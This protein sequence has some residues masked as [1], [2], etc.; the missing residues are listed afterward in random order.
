MRCVH[1]QNHQIS[2]SPGDW[3]ELGAEGLAEQML[4]LQAQGAHNISLVTPS[5]VVPQVVA[6]LEI[7]AAAG[8]ELPLVYNTS[9][10]D[11]V[12]VLGELDGVVDIYLPDFKYGD[13]SSAGLISKVGDYVSTARRAL[14]EM[15]RQVGELCTDGEGVAWR[16]LILRHLVLPGGLSASEQVLRYV[17]ARLGSRTH[18]SLMAQ[19][20]PPVGRDL[21]P[22]LHRPLRPSEYEAPRALL[23][24]LGLHL[25]W[26][27]DLVS[28]DIYVPD[29]DVEAHP[30][31]P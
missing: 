6:A 22:P 4:S 19:Y 23:G 12:P 11:R 1:C 21:P 10:Y 30:F 2:L 25:G 24:E 3:T 31:E 15:N 28:A 20:H 9:A 13:E 5:H 27:Q 16:G 7:A 29:F 17:A 8:L 14:H 18:V 26:V